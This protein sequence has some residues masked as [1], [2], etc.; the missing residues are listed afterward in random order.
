MSGRKM[1][2][3]RKSAGLTFL[4]VISTICTSEAI[5]TMNEISR[6][7]GA[8]GSTNVFRNHATIEVIVSTKMFA[9]PIRSAVATRAETPMKGH[10]PRKRASVKLLTSIA[11]TKI[12]RSSPVMRPSDHLRVAPRAA[13]GA[14]VASLPRPAPSTRR[15]TGAGSPA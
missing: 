12:Q 8:W 15:A 13:S 10:R 5:T 11:E 4:I 2:S 6:R 7:Y 9:P 3:S 14:P 1:P